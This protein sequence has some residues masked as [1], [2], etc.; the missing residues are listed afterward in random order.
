MRILHI[1]HGF[2][3]WRPGGLVSYIEDLMDAQVARGYEVAYF[4]SGRHGPL[5][6][7]PRLRRWRRRGVAMYELQGSRG[8]FGEDAG[9]R[10]PDPDLGEPHAERWFRHA[11]DEFDP[12]VVSVL[13]LGGLP[14]S[15]IDLAREAAKPV[16]MTV[17]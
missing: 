6:S 12:D 8:I 15:L 4:L 7:R 10:Y 11:L 9:T 1:G 14:S 5:R 2:R 13:D 17:H 3:P 16:V